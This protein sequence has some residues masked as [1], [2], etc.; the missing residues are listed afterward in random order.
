[1]LTTGGQNIKIA[2]VSDIHG[3]S[4]ALESVLADIR[5]RGINEIYD[6]GDSLYG[7]LD[8]MGTFDLIKKNN[9]KS[10]SGNED[11]LILENTGKVPENNTLRYV[12]HSLDTEAI[13]W[14]RSLPFTRQIY[15]DLFLCH[16][17][18]SSDTEY[19]VEELKGDFVALK[20]EELL[21]E[22]F[23]TTNEKIVL[24]GHSHCQRIVE[25]CEK[26]IINPGSVGCPAF[27]DDLPI[28]HKMENFSP[29]ARYCIIE[30]SE[31]IKIDQVA[32]SYDFEKPAK[33]ALENNRSD[34]A[35]WIRTGKA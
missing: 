20:S 1:M 14:L 13:S 28:Y 33:K 17:T 26:I 32:L 21:K 2:V 18:P 30:A 5:K 35:R 16:G 7:P 27:D 9:I 29:M 8:P 15:N 6:L 4:W 25:A 11:R 3:N 22:S 31:K 10:I 23:K 12:L 34:W 19:L 24:C